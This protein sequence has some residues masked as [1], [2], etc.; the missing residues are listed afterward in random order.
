MRTYGF[1]A[2]CLALGVFP[3]CASPPSFPPAY[4]IIGDIFF[5]ECAI[6]EDTLTSGQDALRHPPTA[7]QRDLLAHPFIFSRTSHYSMLFHRALGPSEWSVQLSAEEP[8]Q[9]WA[10]SYEKRRGEDGK[11]IDCDGLT[12]VI[13][14]ASLS[15]E[16]MDTPGCFSRI[17]AVFDEDD[18]LVGIRFVS[19]HEPAD[20]PSPGCK[21]APLP[22]LTAQDVR[23]EAW[24][25]PEQELWRQGRIQLVELKLRLDEG[26][27]IDPALREPLRMAYQLDAVFQID[28]QELFHESQVE[29]GTVTIEWTGP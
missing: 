5:L 12:G 24:P 4:G 15:S 10:A 23:L 16:N 3:A 8:A 14:T 18:Q 17:G 22:T 11:D 29:G 9:A 21:V 25:E 26:D 1:R 13:Q 28:G 19:I 27:G 2:A 20:D 7:S 6:T